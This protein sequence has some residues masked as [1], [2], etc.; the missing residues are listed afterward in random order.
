MIFRLNNHKL[1]FLDFYAQKSILGQVREGRI[2][3][4]ALIWKPYFRH[5]GLF[6]WSIAAN[7]L[8]CIVMV[9]R[10]QNR[11]FVRAH[12]DHTDKK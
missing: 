1:K 4:D 8:F 2:I 9:I 11:Y 7:N 6:A 3:S 12:D 10:R 5:D